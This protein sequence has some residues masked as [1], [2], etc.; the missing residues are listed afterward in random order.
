[1]ESLVGF[2]GFAEKIRKVPEGGAGEG[3]D[4]PGAPG[5]GAQDVVHLCRFHGQDKIRVFQQIRG[6]GLG[7]VGADVDA[8]RC[9]G[10]DGERVRQM[11]KGCAQACRLDVQGG[12]ARGEHPSGDGAPADVPLA[13]DQDASYQGWDSSVCTFTAAPVAPFR[14]VDIG[15]RS[16]NTLFQRLRPD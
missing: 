2:Q 7:S 8:V 14:T 1:M 5:I 13:D 4:L 6:D 12:K 3:P 15:T 11:S 9:A 16:W 10:L